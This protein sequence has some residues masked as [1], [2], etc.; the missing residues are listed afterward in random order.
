MWGRWPTWTRRST[1]AV[2]RWPRPPPTTPTG[3]VPRQ[4]GDRGAGPASSVRESRPTW[5]RRSSPPGGGGRDPRRPSGPCRVPQQPRDRGAHALRAD[6]RARRPGRGDR[7][8]PGG[9]RTPPLPTTRTGPSPPQPGDRVAG[10]GSSGRER[11]ADLAEA[12]EAARRR[13]PRPPPTTRT[14]PC[15]STTWAS[16]LRTRFESTGA[17]ADLEAALSATRSGRGRFGRAVDSD[18]RGPA[19]AGGGGRVP[20]PAVRPGCWRMRCCCCPRWRRAGW[21]VVTSSTRSVGSPGWPPTRPRLVLAGSAAP[22][23]ERAVRAL[24]LLEAGRA[25]L[26][27]Q[28]LETRSDLT[29]L[30][31]RHPELAE[32]FTELRELLDQ[33]VP[34]PSR[35][36]PG[37]GDR[38]GH[39]SAPAAGPG[40]TSAGRPS[41]PRSW[42]RSAALEGFASF[43]RPPDDR[44][45]CSARPR[46]G[47]VVTFNV[48]SYRSDALILTTGG[49][50]ALELPAP[51]P[52]LPDRPDQ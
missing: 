2:R 47:P 16:T 28:A 7:G 4:P 15:T 8:R 38:P 51:D 39:R 20:T 19:G 52:R 31:E 25:V 17:R 32:R 13:W 44:R 46:H 1:S 30:R 18:P 5:P 42:I 49:V 12:I 21:S 43:A 45:S 11:R 33:P 9:R 24:R 23:D 26:L 22:A 41:S 40:S 34:L 50:T 48:S 14:G 27:S 6:G 3:P 10:H 29:D 36:P 35:Q 37:A